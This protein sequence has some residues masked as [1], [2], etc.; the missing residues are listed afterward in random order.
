MDITVNNNKVTCNKYI[1]Q[2]T[3]F[4]IISMM[5]SFVSLIAT[6]QI[7][8]LFFGLSANISM[9]IGFIVAE[10]VLF[11]LQKFFVYRDKGISS[12]S[13]EIIFSFI[14]SGIHLALY[15]LI[16]YIFCNYLHLFEFTSFLIA[17]VLITILEYPFSKIIKFEFYNEAQKEPF[18]NL[19]CKLFNFRFVILS[20]LIALAS[21]GFIYTVFKVFPFGDT[22]VLR[23]DLYHQ[24]GPLFTELY[25]RITNADSF[26]YSWTS[27]GGS[28]FIGNFFNYLSSPLNILILLF[29][30]DEMSY[31]IS[32]LV[33]LKCMISAAT[34]TY[35]LKK[36]KNRHS[37][38]SASFGVLYSFSA[39]FLAYFWNI[40]WLDAMFI[41]PL[42]ALGI[43]NILNKNNAKLYTISLIYILFANYYMGF[44]ICIF[45]VIYFL[46]YFLISNNSEN[47]LC[48]KNPI[49][50]FNIINKI[51]ENFFISR[52]LKFA[53]SSLLAGLVCAFFLIPV[54]FILTGSSAT[55]GTFP[56]E[57]ESYFTLFDFIESHFAGLE[58]TIRSSG[59]DILPNIYCGV[60]TLI[61]LPLFL[62]NKKIKTNEKFVYTSLLI[63]FFIF[64]N[65][66]FTNYIWHAFHFP[67]DLPYRFSFMYSFLLL[68]VC[69][70]SLMNLD[71]IN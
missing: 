67:N 44:M 61:L 47:T 2:E 65:N 37:I 31:A 38:V 12:L 13:K 14:G 70:I 53:F 40:M 10:I 25:D 50:K 5:I 60:F 21:I 11:F 15:F 39:Y 48:V 71:G 62:I 49:S 18:T 46:A 8:K 55:S 3:I 33:A 58:T 26:L 41:L 1:N 35:Y 32:F 59:N 57:A 45:S 54:F 16:N 4:H 64:F 28:A 23:M 69:F 22:T 68:V 66:N 30:R 52:G 43:E 24:Y 19:Y 63:L 9:I 34:F 17:F 36:S 29:N 51:N 27:G 56:T 42:I 20:S 7:F 6:K